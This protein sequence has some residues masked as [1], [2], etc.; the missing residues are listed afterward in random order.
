MLRN[1]LAGPAMMKL[2]NDPQVSHVPI[3]YGIEDSLPGLE[4]RVASTT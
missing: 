4:K 1:G 3:A 2:K